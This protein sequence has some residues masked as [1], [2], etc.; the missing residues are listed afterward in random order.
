MRTKIESES[1]V[2]K[3]FH[4]WLKHWNLN[5]YNDQMR[6]MIPNE[7]SEGFKLLLNY[8]LNLVTIWKYKIDYIVRHNS[9]LWDCGVFSFVLQTTCAYI[10]GQYLFN[11]CRMVPHPSKFLTCIIVF[12]VSFKGS[13]KYMF[14]KKKKWV[15][16]RCS[17]FLIVYNDWQKI[18]KSETLAF[19]GDIIFLNR[20]VVTHV[21]Q[22]DFYGK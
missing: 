11:D 16:S 9:I 17:W 1:W 15:S 20:W 3:L 7:I 2:T 4:V 18:F 12:G 22:L 5:E 21:L 10:W 19:S 14:E 13:T 6:Y 8:I